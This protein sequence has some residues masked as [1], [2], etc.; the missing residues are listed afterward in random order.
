MHP[1]AT[2]EPKHLE[3]PAEETASTVTH[4]IGGLLAA[5]ALVALVIAAART[6]DARRIIA[7][8]IYGASLVLLYSAST[9]Y[10]LVR[11]PRL[12][13]ML[14]ILDH[15]AIYLL[16]AGTYTPILL[17]SLRGT[18][19]WSLFAVIW[20]MAVAG[21]VLKLFF[22]DRFKS[23]STMVYVLMGWLV[24]IGIKPLFASVP[25]WGIVWLLAGGLAY[26]GGVVFYL[27]DR[28]P[29]NHAIWHLF[30]IAGSVFHFLAVWIYVLPV[31]R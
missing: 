31:V 11:Q 20:T 7:V 28:L 15:A 10:H 4:A 29:F 16:I 6:D 2:C 22:V 8:S 12:K 23:I 25:V 9:C 17:I 5:I 24:V 1:E 14:K 13:R 18:W 26:T 21:I 27:W 19:G 3:T 30:V